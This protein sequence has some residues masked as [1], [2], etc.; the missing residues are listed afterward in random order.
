M[1]PNHHQW[2]QR[3]RHSL[4]HLPREIQLQ[5]C[6]YLCGHC[7]GETK[8]FDGWPGV[9]AGQRALLALSQTSTAFHGLAQPIAYHAFSGVP[10]QFLQFVRTLTERPDLAD[11]VKAL[12][13]G[14]YEPAGWSSEQDQG[15]YTQTTYT[16]L[17]RR[18]KKLGSAATLERL[19]RVMLETEETWGFYYSNPAIGVM[20]RLAPNLEEVVIRCN[21]GLEG[22]SQGTEDRVFPE[23]PQPIRVLRLIDCALADDPQSELFLDLLVRNAPKLEH[24][25]YGS[26]LAYF[27]ESMGPHLSH[28]AMLRCLSPTSATLKS[29]DIDLT[30]HSE[31][32]APSLVTAQT[33]ASFAKLEVLK[34]DETA[35]CRHYGT[36]EQQQDTSGGTCLVEIIPSTLKLLAVRLYDGSRLWPELEELASRSSMFPNLQKLVVYAISRLFSPIDWSVFKEQVRHEAKKLQ[37]LFDKTHIKLEVT[38]H[39]DY[40]PYQEIG[41]LRPSHP[42]GDVSLACSLLLLESS[43]PL[44]SN[45]IAR[46][47]F[48][49]SRRIIGILPT[50]CSFTSRPRTRRIRMETYQLWVGGQTVAGNGEELSIKNPATGELVAKCHTASDEDIDAAIHTAQDA[51][52]SGVWSNC[53]RQTRAEVLEKAASLLADELQTLIPLEVQQTG[54][55]IREMQ[56]QVPSLVRWFRYY[57]ALL[58]TEERAVLPT[59]GKL[60]NWVDRIPLG[61]VVQITPFN[62]PLLI[63]VKKLAPALA[64][65]NSIL[66]KPSELTPLTSLRLGPI[67]KAAGLPD[68]VFNVVPGLGAVTGRALTSHPLVRKVDITGGTAAGRAIGALAGQNLARLTAELGGKAPVVVLKDADIDAAVNGVAFGAFIASGQTCVAATRIIVERS[69]SS[70]FLSKLTSKAKTICD[71]MGL[72]TNPA[73]TM[74]PVISERQLEKLE[75]LV[76]DAVSSG[77]AVALC[78]GGRLTGSSKLDGISFADG[79]FY[80]PTILVSATGNSVT[81][82]RIWREEAFGP[83][84]VVVEFDTEPEAIA[85]AND[86]EFGLGAAIWT[87]DI[88]QAFQISQN[89]RAGIIWVNTH[90]RNDPSSPWGG[91]TSSSGVGSENGLDAYHAYTTIKSTIIN[92]ASSEE[93]KELE[94]WFGAQDRQ[95]RYG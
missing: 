26:Q 91:A 61:V 86:T 19:R 6:S 79:F 21:K 75:S 57:A 13:Q 9:D 2:H 60:H 24:F 44:D 46:A 88:S 73:S 58:R 94:D 35:F 3:P 22:I 54:R 28:G 11:E 42:L 51:F 48:P 68:G 81:Q 49:Y 30:D 52:T 89:I 95:V 41:L 77:K 25:S 80:P 10:G 7:S 27:G 66:L 53:P 69:I 14:T 1:S 90:H 12:R 20:H 4:G 34:L 36:P 85:L 8:R 38:E 47:S 87:K 40:L 5:I 33:V 50:L 32:D 84:I 23:K 93:S 76:D 78:G 18:M 64:A 59:S 65:G 83:A 15:N 82:S 29:I 37:E 71:N 16:Y 92:Y 17:E 55:P 70:G 39:S 63:A 56:A 74:G 31:H 62:H 67:L 45:C 72:P 43:S